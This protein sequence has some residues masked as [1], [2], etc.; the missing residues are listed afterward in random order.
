MDITYP[1][2]V[3]E[4]A[5]L[6][7]LQALDI[8]G[9]THNPEFDN[10][11]ELTRALF[12][13]PIVAITLVDETQQHI[14]SGFGLDVCFIP[15]E[16]S[17]C[18]YTI[19]RGTLFVVEDLRIDPELRRLLPLIDGR[20]MCFYAGVP[21]SIEPD[22]HL[23]A[24]CIGDVKP[25]TITSVEASHLYRLAGLASTLLRHRK[26]LLE[27]EAANASLRDQLRKN[28]EQSRALVRS[29]TL[30]DR[31]SALTKIGSWERSVDTEGILWS[32]GMYDIFELEVGKALVL[33]EIFAM[34]PA[35]YRAIFDKVVDS[36]VTDRNGFDDEILITT[37]KGNKRWVRETWNI[38]RS[39]DRPDCL[40]GIIQDI[41]DQKAVWDRMRFLAERD[42]LTGLPNRS[43]LQS[44]LEHLSI[45]P[46]PEQVSLVLIDLDGFKHINDTFGHDVGDECLKQIANRLKRSS[47][48]IDVLARVGGDEFALL[49]RRT[50]R[51]A[52]EARAVDILRLLRRPIHWRGKSFQVSGSIG[53]TFKDQ[54]DFAPLHIFTEADLALYAAKAAGRNVFRIFDLDMKRKADV[55][56]E[57]V[58]SVTRAL[59]QGELELFYQPKIL[60]ADGKLSGFEALLR[61]CRPD[62]RI[63]VAGA[64][65]AALEDPELSERIGDW[66]VDTALSQARTWHLADLDFGHIAINLS[67]S[68]FREVAFADRLIAMI[69]AHGLRTDM[70]EVEI[71]EGVFLNPEGGIVREILEKLRTAGIR[72]A[73][74]D[75]GTGYASLSHLRT[76]PVDIIKLDRSFIQHVLTSP[77]DHS[78]VQATLFLARQL[79]VDVVAEG[80]E[81]QDQFQ[82]LSALGC[83]YGQGW[84]F[85]KALPAIEATQ[86]CISVPEMLAAS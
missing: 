9:S 24:L 11:V 64:L 59:Q 41:T 74:D 13:V 72:I 85:A 45:G 26:I 25:R 37:A 43:L 28:E 86:W 75:F 39:L 18:N 32:S 61:W 42:L 78:I 17:I 56:F 31:A 34:F 8:L 3:N 23:G 36:N 66:V 40:F 84:L 51:K 62:G 65:S 20:P 83:E 70:I 54:V 4:V 81:A 48:S 6:A 77:Q 29:Q 80:I 58:K 5:R 19:T 50:N 76:Y 53:I 14:K 1:R 47:R 22:V 35:G 71:T 15:R 55:R 60:L 63:I 7:A 21:I 68:Q 57:T 10:I 69:V 16:S 2:P 73:L 67:P 79:K 12:Q 33:D 44:R 27:N 52:I 30:F 46:L 82:F 38:D 49:V